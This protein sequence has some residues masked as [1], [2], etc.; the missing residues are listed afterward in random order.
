MSHKQ[1]VEELEKLLGIVTSMRK[2]IPCEYELKLKK[3]LIQRANHMQNGIFDWSKVKRSV[4]GLAEILQ[5]NQKL[6]QQAQETTERYLYAKSA[7]QQSSN[8]LK[9]VAETLKKIQQIKKNNAK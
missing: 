8:E 1:Q 7:N 9:D 6:T 2:T 3:I 5:Q 4:D